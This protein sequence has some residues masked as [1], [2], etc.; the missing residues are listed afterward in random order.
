MKF[1]ADGM[2]GFSKTRFKQI[3]GIANPY[4][5]GKTL[6]SFPFVLT[7]E[8]TVEGGEGAPTGVEFG[9]HFQIDLLKS[10]ASTTAYSTPKTNFLLI[11]L[12]IKINYIDLP[13]LKSNTFSAAQNS[14]RHNTSE[15][16]KGG[17]TQGLT[18]SRAP[19]QKTALI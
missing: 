3:P 10:S 7:G 14:R 17:W 12:A 5:L 4:A 18:S 19:S 2:Q 6:K 1:Q 9:K 13:C 16:Y 15:I 8:V 11:F